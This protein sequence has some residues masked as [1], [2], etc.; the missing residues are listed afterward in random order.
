MLG[1]FGDTSIKLDPDKFEEEDARTFAR[2]VATEIEAERTKSGGNKK[3]L[4]TNALFGV[5]DGDGE[6]IVADLTPWFEYLSRL[7]VVERVAAEIERDVTTTL[8]IIM[9]WLSPPNWQTFFWMRAY[10]ER[11][12]NTLPVSEANRLVKRAIKDRASQAAKLAGQASGRRRKLVSLDAA[13]VRTEAD[14]LTRAGIKAH[15]IAS[16]MAKSF[17]VTP[18]RIRQILRSQK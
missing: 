17:H 7:E 15:K 13:G 12:A 9:D 6:S 11:L 5:L 14:R 2:I 4:G 10:I 18:D 1:I 16:T 3:R 8:T